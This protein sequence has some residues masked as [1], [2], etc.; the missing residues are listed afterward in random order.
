MTT[1]KLSKKNKARMKGKRQLMENS[2]A[3]T[4]SSSSS[5]LY[6]QYMLLAVKVLMVVIILLWL[7]PL[8]TSS[9]N[10]RRR[11]N[12]R[13]HTGTSK[14]IHQQLHRHRLDCEMDC[15]EVVHK[16]ILPSVE[17][18]NCIF[19]CLSPACFQEIYQPITLEPGEVDIQRYELFEACAQEEIREKRKQQQATPQAKKP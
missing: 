2:N 12:Q 4:S 6:S 13:R 10:K 1:L 7:P 18:M 9:K 15:L 11:N 3:S 5:S 19:A 14:T 8:V 17:S 16:R